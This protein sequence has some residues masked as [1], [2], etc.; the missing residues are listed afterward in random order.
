MPTIRILHAS[1]LHISVHQNMVSPID[2]FSNLRAQGNLGF[3]TLV[4]LARMA[5]KAFRQKM[6]ASSYESNV[7]KHLAK[8]IYDRSR[9]KLKG[10]QL[11]FEDGADKID[12][13]VLSGDLATTGDPDDIDMVKDFLF[14]APGDLRYPYE[15][16]IHEAT[17]SAVKS[18]IWYFPGNHDRFQGTTDWTSFRKIRFPKLFEPGGDEFDLKLKDFK[19]HPAQIL[20][21]TP[22]WSTGVVPLRV[23]VIAAD[24]SLRQFGDHEGLYG[25]LAQ[26]RVQGTG[27]E[28]ILKELVAETQKE[29][30]RHEQQGEGTLCIFWAVHFPPGF[31]HISSTNRLMGE[32]YLIEEA[33]SCGVNAILAG[34]THEQV[35]Y[36]KPSMNFDVICCGSTTQ[37]MPPNTQGRNR[38]EIINVTTNNRN[39]PV[40]TMEN[41]K[42]MRAAHDGVARTEFYIEN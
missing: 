33:K 31:P 2:H 1:D 17:L 32:E 20:G 23:T 14:S 22:D 10:G 5:Y 29:M 19:N 8:F 39:E 36:R 18:P 13:I 28:D 40:I 42:Y 4:K 27:Y 26:G 11:V 21:T 37:H 41:Y 38:F 3:V 25:W 35:R 6:T 16:L 34:H 15:N 9:Q 12:A 7:L 30:N 24:F